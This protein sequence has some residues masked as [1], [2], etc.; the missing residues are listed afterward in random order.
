MTLNNYSNY[1]GEGG[2][3]RSHVDFGVCL[4]ESGN[5][6]LL[7][8]ETILNFPICFSQNKECEKRIGKF[9][10]FSSHA[11]VNST[12]EID[13]VFLGKIQRNWF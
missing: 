3:F 6:S 7:C 4:Y 2:G 1:T 11:Y 9:M 8:Y 12:F 10:M 5:F 13:E